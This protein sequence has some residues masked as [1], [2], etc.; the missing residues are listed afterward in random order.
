MQA[1]LTS[2]RRTIHC[3]TPNQVT[4]Q[5]DFGVVSYNRVDELSAKY[6]CLVL[7]QFPL[8]MN[9]LVVLLPDNALFVYA[10][11]APLLRTTGISLHSLHFSISLVVV[12][13]RS[14]PS[15]NFCNQQ[16]N[17]SG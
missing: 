6:V 16:T 4:S 17:L 5:P 7:I 2:E 8:G 1:T 11:L 9:G 13:Y 12:S 3:D 14:R 15:W 10:V